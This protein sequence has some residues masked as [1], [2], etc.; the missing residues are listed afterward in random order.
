VVWLGIAIGLALGLLVSFQVSAGLETWFWLLWCAFIVPACS[1][2]GGLL[3]GFALASGGAQKSG[4][5]SKKAKIGRQ[6][7][8]T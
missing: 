4:G 1:A 3:A 2:S 8:S 6:G 5:K 7:P